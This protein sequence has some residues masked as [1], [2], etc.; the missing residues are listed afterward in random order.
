MSIIMSPTGVFSVFF[1]LVPVWMT[2]LFPSFTA[3]AFWVLSIAW[4][5]CWCSTPWCSW[6]P[7]TFSTLIYA[8]TCG[9][10]VCFIFLILYW[11]SAESWSFWN[12]SSAMT[13]YF[14]NLS[15]SS[16]TT[17]IRKLVVLV[18][19]ADRLLTMIC[20]GL[21]SFGRSL[22]VDF[23]SP[24]VWIVYAFVC[25]VSVIVIMCMWAFCCYLLFDLRDLTFPFLPSGA[26]L[27]S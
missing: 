22:G 26:F 23:I 13:L 20:A 2:I 25:C 9:D 1:A 4:D 17:S 15:S 6:L 24:P 27:P 14:K 12:R 10:C 3:P 18:V 8:L 11:R 5:C 16:V 19:N 7:S 21:T